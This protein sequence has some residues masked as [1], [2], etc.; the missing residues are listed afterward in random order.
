MLNVKYN[1]EASYS[2]EWMDIPQFQLGCQ[3]CN[4][5]TPPCYSQRRRRTWAADQ[6]KCMNHCAVSI[7]S[8]NKLLQGLFPDTMEGG[9]DLN[10]EDV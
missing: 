1:L 10:T 9:K 6:G 8:C 2:W 7:N 3:P 5:A 4:R